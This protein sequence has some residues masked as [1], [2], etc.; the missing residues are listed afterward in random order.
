MT[1]TSFLI[2]SMALSTA[3]AAASRADADVVATPTIEQ[4]YTSSYFGGVHLGVGLSER[5]LD[6]HT[7]QDRA[8]GDKAGLGVQLSAGYDRVFSNRWVVGAEGALGT[9]GPK[10]T[11][12]SPASG[13]Y[14]EQIRPDIDFRA[15]LRAGY[16]LT[17]ATLLYGRVGYDW[18]GLSHR[19]LTPV[20]LD[21]AH[22]GR[23]QG[24]LFG[25]GVEQALTNR[26]GVRVEYDRI[27]RSRGLEADD[28]TV[29]AHLKF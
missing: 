2:A 27:D 6:F 10:V 20:A 8:R 28:V 7:P 5:R 14:T 1:K 12:Y 13:V 21:D 17:P 25:V 18:Q 22:G 26:F 24:P 15:S 3:T 11:T 4:T 29:S 19:L 23:A 9:D 16:L